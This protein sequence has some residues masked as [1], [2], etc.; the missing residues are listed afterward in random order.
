MNPIVFAAIIALAS[1]AYL[2]NIGMETYSMSVHYAKVKGIEGDLNAI[3]MKQAIYDDLYSI[4]R[5]PSNNDIPAISD[6]AFGDTLSREY[7][8]AERS[9]MKRVSYAIKQYYERTGEITTAP[10]CEQL[11]SNGD[12]SIDDDDYA[13]CIKMQ[14]IPFNGVSVAA[15]GT[16]EYT[17]EDAKIKTGLQDLSNTSPLMTTGANSVLKS[18]TVRPIKISQAQNRY[19]KKMENQLV[20]LFRNH[21]KEAIDKLMSIKDKIPPEQFAIM[22]Q[23]ITSEIARAIKYRDIGSDLYAMSETQKQNFFGDALSKSE[24]LTADSSYNDT[25]KDI[26]REGAN[27]FSSHLE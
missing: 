26:F 10:T 22:Y 18:G 25:Q 15:N 24:A 8:S 13:V 3:K 20:Q 1:G 6:T 16:A 21:P 2:A 5:L 12:F 17:P 4:N 9:A 7:N 23:K 27:L 11:K 14:T 19:R